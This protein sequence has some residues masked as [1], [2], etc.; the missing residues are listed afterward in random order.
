MEDVHK[1]WKHRWVTPKAKP[2]ASS[3]HGW[4]VIAVEKI[5]KGEIIAVLGGVIV[6]ISGIKKYR[7]R[8]GHIGIQIDDNF[9]ICPTSR[10][11]LK[12]TGIFNHSCEPNMGY[13]DP[14]TFVAIKDIIPGEE[15][16]FDYAFSESFF[17]P[18]KCNCRNKNCRKVIKQDDWKISEIQK[19]Y[20]QYFSPY[21]KNKIKDGG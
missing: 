18:F 3:I 7:E 13:K 6:P 21:L 20:G 16:T 11:E 19:K 8:L 2:Q 14:I 12:E 1:F 9:F 4:G 10:K 5:F 15:L 17:E